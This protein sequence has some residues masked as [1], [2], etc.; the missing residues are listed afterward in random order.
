MATSDEATRCV[1]EINTQNSVEIL[2]RSRE[3]QGLWAAKSAVDRAHRLRSLSTIILERAEQFAQAIH[4]DTGMLITDALA[5]EIL[6]AAR[7]IDQWSLQ[8]ESL[9]ESSPLEFNPL[10]LP[11]KSARIERAPRGV[12]AVLTSSLSPLLSPIRHGLPALLSG[13]ALWLKPD[14]RTPRTTNLI[15]SS[16]SGL[17]PADVVFV[18]PGGAEVGEFIIKSG[19]AAVFFSGGLDAAK[20]VAVCCAHDFIPCFVEVLRKTGAVVLDDASIERTARGLVWAAFAKGGQGV[21]SLGHVFVHQ[22]IAD[23]LAERIATL[24]K[25]L[26]AG[27]D[28]APPPLQQ[29]SQALLTQLSTD[30]EGITVLAGGKSDPEQNVFPPTVVRVALEQVSWL[31]SFEKAPVLSLVVV[32]D[33]KQALELAKNSALGPTISVWTRH[34]ER[35]QEIAQGLRENVWTVNHHGV[36]SPLVGMPWSTT[37]RTLD[38]I[39]SG[40][41][42]FDKHSCSK[43]VL[44]D[45]CT[46]SRELGWYPYDD[47]YQRMLVETARLQSGGWLG[48][49]MA[50]LRL[51]V[52]Y[53]KRWLS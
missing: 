4:D 40:S 43:L 46:R 50:L 15:A 28:H 13:N 10:V 42:D 52:L 11:R 30:N 47:T 19:V 32:K 36:P 24:T 45:R 2:A 14:E 34:A 48:R 7:L 37:E 29:R 33:E 3:A 20:R 39:V 18:V 27:I 1:I 31:P 51:L 22:A 25:E 6:P 44:V 21:H 41:S 38:L 23:S 49:L 53:P 8:A 16:L 5:L 26:R 35:G 17:L 12:V 9:L